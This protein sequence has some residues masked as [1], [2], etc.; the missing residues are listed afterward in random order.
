MALSRLDTDIA[1]H[2][3][4]HLAPR[5]DLR[6]RLAEIDIPTLVITGRHDWVCPPAGGRAIADAVRGAELVELPDA[7]HFGFSETPG[8][9][10]AAV[11]AHLAR[12]AAQP[13][14]EIKVRR[15]A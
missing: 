14:G 15:A 8:P 11:R 10:R 3:F 4:A 13:T 5:Y 1:G 12:I 6:P 9:F 7:G 2:F